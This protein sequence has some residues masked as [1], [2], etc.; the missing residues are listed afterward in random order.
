[1]SLKRYDYVFK[2]IK[3]INVYDNFLNKEDWSKAEDLLLGDH[4]CYPPARNKYHSYTNVWRILKPEIEEPIGELL[5]NQLNK[6]IIDDI[7]LSVKRVGINGSMPLIES[8]PHVDGPPGHWTLLWYANKEWLQEW[9]GGIQIFH[10]ENAYAYDGTP[11]RRP[12]RSLGSTIIECEP[13]RAILFPSHLVHIP[14]SPH[15]VAAHKLRISVGLH[16][17]PSEEWKYVYKGREVK[18]KFFSEDK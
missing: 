4:W 5:Y 6:T 18:R 10:D 1:M 2:R 17:E 12:D 14:E 15:P 7:A 8:H 9:A 16:L 11:Y 3:M 13:N